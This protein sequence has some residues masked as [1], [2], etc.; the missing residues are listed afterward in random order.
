M[1]K[2]DLLAAVLFIALLYTGY[3]L[4]TGPSV[5]G[6]AVYSPEMFN[7][8]FVSPTPANNAILSE[9][10]ITINITSAVNLTSAWVEWNNAN[11]SMQG[12]GANW[13]IAKTGSGNFTFMVYGNDSYG[14]YSYTEIRAVALNFSNSSAGDL[15]GVSLNL[16]TISNITILE[17]STANWSVDLWS[18]TQS[19][20]NFSLLNYTILSQ[21]NSSVLNCLIVS[22]RYVNCSLIANQSGNSL[23]NLRV[24]YSTVFA[25]RLFSII[26]VAVN[27][28]PYFTGTIPNIYMRYTQNAT[29]VLSSYFVDIDNSSLVYGVSSI[30]N[31]T[32]NISGSN[33]YVCPQNGFFGNRTLNFSA[34][35]GYN[36]TYSNNFVINV[37]APNATIPVN[38]TPATVLTL[39][40]QQPSIMRI[41]GPSWNKGSEFIL[42][43][44]KYFSDV[45]ENPSYTITGLSN[46]AYTIVG[47]VVIF[48]AE[49][50]WYGSETAVIHLKSSK[51][52]FSSE[53]F[54]LTVVN[55]NKAP[56]LKR[57]MPILAF[58]E[59]AK[60]IT[61]NLDDYFT[62][63]DGDQLEYDI[64]QSKALNI[65]RGSKNWV[66]F[67]LAPSFAEVETETLTISAEDPEGEKISDSVLVTI[68]KSL[69]KGFDIGNYGLQLLAIILIGTVLILGYR[70]FMPGGYKPGIVGRDRQFRPSG[71]SKFHDAKLHDVK[72]MNY[73]YAEP[74]MKVEPASFIS[75]G[76]SWVKDAI[77]ERK[78]DTRL[79]KELL[80]I[81]EAIASIRALKASTSDRLTAAALLKEEQTLLKA[82]QSL[83]IRKDLK[84]MRKELLYLKDVR[85]SLRNLRDVSTDKVVNAELANTLR[86]VADAHDELASKVSTASN[87]L[88]N[89]PEKQ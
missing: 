72:L 24:N 76:I 67:T 23:L 36:I 62:D 20:K 56:E 2:R 55:T 64:S 16:T 71:V 21:G 35:D 45:G 65:S 43:L 83:M 6:Y 4:F 77:G 59:T 39:N 52:D 19:N 48:R 42:D 15:T 75:G 50:S 85:T 88:Y 3:L 69:R 80:Y 44:G 29:V 34:D 25:D 12:S 33:A 22:N 66:V 30:S 31:I 58:N 11:E 26:V 32:V 84:D 68:A 57:D 47:G 89:L 17:D 82:M 51:G 53:P 73:D 14:N 8:S 13:H 49:K 10:S 37:T 70:K 40:V 79:S 46:I 61:L 41:E 38:T 27:D 9:S 28:A 78:A 86:N 74:G 81:R 5:T 7:L 18:Y 54:T 1:E 60:K 63:P 87:P